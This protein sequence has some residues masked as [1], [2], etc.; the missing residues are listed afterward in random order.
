[1]IFYRPI[2]NSVEIVRVAHGRRDIER[3][4]SGEE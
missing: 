1:M 3:L 2:M 4:F